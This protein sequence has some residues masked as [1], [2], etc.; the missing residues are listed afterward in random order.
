MPSDFVHRRKHGARANPLATVFLAPAIAVAGFLTC[1]S[2]PA[3]AQAFSGAFGGGERTANLPVSIT[4]D[5]LEVLQN[6]RQA[7]FIGDVI[8]TRGTV[9]L[10]SQRLVVHYVEKGKGAA[11]RKTEIVR[12]NAY[13]KVVW[14]NGKQRATGQ[15]AVVYM[16][17]G[18]VTMGDRVVLTEN[19]NVI[20]GSRL[21]INL[22][23]GKSRL[24]GMKQP[25][26]KRRVF[27][28]FVPEPVKK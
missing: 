22:K 24:T 21:K 1:S 16:R 6:K 9:R 26:G 13:G 25:S 5:V 27:G 23:S 19:K 18:I 17:T 8:A 11:N 4:A 14:V 7:I 15:W 20:R 12:L 3:G 10:R 2:I 28:I